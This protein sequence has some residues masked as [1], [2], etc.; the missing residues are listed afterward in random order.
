V[1]LLRRISTHMPAM[2]ALDSVVYYGVYIHMS[3]EESA[4]MKLM[5]IGEVSKRAEVGIETIRYYE[6]EGLLSEPERRPSGYRQYD[7]SVVARLHFIRRA[8]EL[9][10][11]LG[12]IG[13]LLGLR[14][15][16][17]TKCV[18]VR[19]RAE[20]KIQDIEAKI[21]SLQKMKRSLRKLIRT[22]EHR[23]SIEACPLLNGLDDETR[24]AGRL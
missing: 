6:R 3:C 4:I 7:E 22:C 5:Q 10:F 18:H 12:E 15:D 16:N 20:Q 2:L 19:Q 21:A 11:T 9:G 24:S 13:E 23:D 14:Y 17:K 8:K 1:E